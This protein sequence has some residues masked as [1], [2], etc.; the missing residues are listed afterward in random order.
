MEIVAVSP[1]S[2]TQ[3]IK[4]KSSKFKSIKP[5]SS[6]SKKALVAKPTKSQHEGSVNVNVNG[7]GK[8]ENQRSPKDKEGKLCEISSATLYLLKKVQLLIR[9]LAH[10][11]YHLPNK[12]IVLKIVPN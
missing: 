5:P 9:I 11:Y 2:S 7:E 10:P 12:V 1:Q 4:A 6:V 8:D 3:S